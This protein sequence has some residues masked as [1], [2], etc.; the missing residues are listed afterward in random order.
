MLVNETLNQ[1][2]EIGATILKGIDFDSWIAI[3]TSITFI[4]G[5]IAVILIPF[6]LYLMIGALTHARTSDGRKLQTAMI[7]NPNFWY[8]PLIWTLFGSVLFVIFIWYPF[9]IKWIT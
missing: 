9:W 6:I 4:I 8:A 1:T 5:A 3:T 2:A 7:Q